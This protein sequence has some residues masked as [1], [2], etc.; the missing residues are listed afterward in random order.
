MNIKTIISQKNEQWP[1][2]ASHCEEGTRGMVTN[3][4]SI[5]LHGKIILMSIAQEGEYGWQQ[6]LYI[7]VELTE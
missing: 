4:H 1:L 6:L 3:V 5:Y 2:E 7:S